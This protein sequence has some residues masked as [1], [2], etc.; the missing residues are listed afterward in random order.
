MEHTESDIKILKGKVV[1]ENSDL[2]NQYD[3]ALYIYGCNEKVN[4]RNSKKL[5]SLE[6]ELYSIKAKNEH[7]TIK[8]FNPPTD[9]T[10]SVKNTNFQSILEIKK[11]TEVMLIWNVDTPD[12]LTNGSRGKLLDVELTKEGVVKRLIIQF[13]NQNHG[14]RNRQENPCIKYPTGTYIDPVLFQYQLGASNATVYQFPIRLAFAITAHKI[15]GQTICKPQKLVIDIESAFIAG[16]VYVMLSR[17][18]SLEQLIIISHKSG[19]R[20]KEVEKKKED[21][22]S[23][24]IDWN[25][26]Q[27]NKSVLTEVE[28]MEKVSKNMN[29][30]NWDNLKVKGLRLTSLN[31]RSLKKHIKDVREDKISMKSD[32]ICLQETWLE[33]KIMGIPT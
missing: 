31:I 1:S 14:R 9:K 27:A 19:R 25:K 18:C 15:Q 20:M 22:T 8:N 5:Q 24:K 33:D 13:Y 16:M 12:G 29:P 30:N 4:K 26:I 11:G 32:I 23:E 21:M 7:R 6:G 28:R 17:V 3:D 10:G 2:L